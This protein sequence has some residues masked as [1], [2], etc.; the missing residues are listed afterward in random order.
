METWRNIVLSESLG[1]NLNYKMIFGNI[2]VVYF[3]TIRV[4]KCARNTNL[5][6]ECNAEHRA[7]F[8]LHTSTAQRKGCDAVNYI[9][10]YAVSSCTNLCRIWDAISRIEAWFC[11]FMWDNM[12]WARLFP[13]EQGKEIN[14]FT[15]SKYNYYKPKLIL[16]NNKI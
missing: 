4:W 16:L 10:N 1:F 6:V 8:T 5:R 15:G 14:E 7:T 11:S 12:I 13:T 9:W 3:V 2:I